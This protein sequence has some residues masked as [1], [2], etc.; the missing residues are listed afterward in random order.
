MFHQVYLK[1]KGRGGVGEHVVRR[2]V[3]SHPQLVI[4]VV[5]TELRGLCS[6]LWSLVG[7]L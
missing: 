2:A 4:G 1:T 5:M 6:V 7:G 3:C